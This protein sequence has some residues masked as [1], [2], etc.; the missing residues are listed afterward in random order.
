MLL[1]PL[2]LFYPF[3][4]TLLP[5]FGNKHFVLCVYEFFSFFVGFFLFVSFDRFPFNT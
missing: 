3:F 4:H 5:T 1:N 2:H